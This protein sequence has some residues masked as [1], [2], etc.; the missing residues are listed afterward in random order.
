[1]LLQ[2]IQ[3]RV[4]DRAAMRAQHERWLADI[5]AAADGWLGSTAGITADDRFICLSRFSSAQALAN[6]SARTDQREWWARTERL[7]LGP[8]LTAEFQD[9]VLI[10]EGGADDAGFVQVAQG[11][12]TDPE[13]LRSLEKELVRWLPEGR[14]DIIGGL[15]AVRA[16]GRFVRVF[17]FSS[18]ELA[19]AGEHGEQHAEIEEILFQMRELTGEATYHDLRHP[20]LA[21]PRAGRSLGRSAVEETT[22]PR[23]GRRAAGRR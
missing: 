22:Q 1:M 12:T 11:R 15:A 2:V 23:G 10:L 7:F 16:D 20:W 9:A 14:P 5:G 3:G 8:V 17:S 21:S 13:R 4:P 18:E 19:R 6:L